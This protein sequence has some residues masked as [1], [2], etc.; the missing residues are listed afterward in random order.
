[1]RFLQQDG[2]VFYMSPRR[3]P[4]DTSP[5]VEQMQLE[6]YRRMTPGRKWQLLDDMYRMARQLHAAGVRMENPHATEAE[7]LTAWLRA[8]LEESLFEEVQRYR[9][10]L[11]RRTI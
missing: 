3:S 1:M 4:N 5:E 8:T 10:D 11:A 6:I 7:I 2:G 9:H